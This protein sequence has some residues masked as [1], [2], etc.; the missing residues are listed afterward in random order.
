MMRNVAFFSLRDGR[1]GTLDREVKR[2]VSDWYE[3]YF[4]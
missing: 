1:W 3:R 4:K 2:N